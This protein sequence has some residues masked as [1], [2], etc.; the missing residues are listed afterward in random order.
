M[1]NST[2]TNSVKALA[3]KVLQRNT[4]GNNKE[5]STAIS[6][7]GVNMQTSHKQMSEKETNVL[8]SWQCYDQPAPWGDCADFLMRLHDKGCLAPFCLKTDSWCLTS[9]TY[10]H[11]MESG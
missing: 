2:E 8:C 4:K 9:S 6:C 5:T 3:L 11:V 1:G 10:P 7:Q